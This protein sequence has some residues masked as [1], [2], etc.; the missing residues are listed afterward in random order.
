[1]SGSFAGF[2]ASLIVTPVERIKILL[3]TNKQINKEL[4][5][6]YLFRGLNTTFTRE[7]P[8]FAIYFNVYENLKKYT[9]TNKNL[10]IPIYSSFVFGGG[11][12]IGAWLFIYPQDCIKTRMQANLESTKTFTQVFREIYG[13]GGFKNFYKGFH[14]ALLRAIPLHAGTF[15][16]MEFLNSR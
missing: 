8:G 9:Y 15:A 4:S 1:M 10:E 7:V 11:A 12:A 14:F 16:T 5:F 2:S 13:E 3:Q 6:R